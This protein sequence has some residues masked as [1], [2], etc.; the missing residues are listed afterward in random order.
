[1]TAIEFSFI[2][3]TGTEYQMIVRLMSTFKRETGIEV[4]L[5]R[6]GWDDAWLQL[7]ST[8]HSYRTI[9]LW[10]RIEHQLGVELGAVTAKLFQDPNADFDSLIT[11]TMDSLA[12]R[13]NL[14]L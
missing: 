11:E 4:N 3:D 10:H 5:K 14:T 8:G 1:M 2:P 13:L 7:I 9:A 12:N 6:M